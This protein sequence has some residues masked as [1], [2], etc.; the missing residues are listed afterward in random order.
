MN[1]VLYIVPGMGDTCQQQPYRSLS[2]IAEIKGYK[3]IPVTIDWKKKFSDQM[4]SIPKN[5]VVF[6]FSLGAVYT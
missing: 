5:A 4:I 2:K 3:V 6:G 1:K